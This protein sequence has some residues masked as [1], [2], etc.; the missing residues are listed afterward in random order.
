MSKELQKL[1]EKGRAEVNLMKKSYWD[2]GYNQARLASADELT[3]VIRHGAEPDETQL[4]I[5]GEQGEFEKAVKTKPG[6]AA[7]PMTQLFEF[8]YENPFV[9][10]AWEGW[11][12]RS[13]L[14]SR[15]VPQ[16]AQKIGDENS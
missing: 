5:F 4:T 1:V 8:I 7:F 12:F 15:H 9:Q 6:F 2:G 14:E 10:A 16:P 13:S 11:Q 3:E